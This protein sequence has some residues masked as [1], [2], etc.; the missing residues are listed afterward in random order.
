MQAQALQAQGP[1]AGSDQAILDQLTQIQQQLLIQK[2]SRSNAQNG[3]DGPGEETVLQL[4][5]ALRSIQVSTILRSQCSCA[6]LIVLSD[7]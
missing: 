3:K 2:E 6:C 5:E 1:P 7:A 4:Q